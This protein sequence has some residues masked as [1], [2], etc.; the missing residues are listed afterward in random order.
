MDSVLL[1]FTRYVIRLRRAHPAFTRRSWLHG[2]P[3]D[4]GAEDVMWLTPA[5]ERM[6]DEDWSNG[7]LKSLMVYLNGCAVAD[8]GPDGERAHDD[9]FIL[10]F[11]ASDKSVEFSLAGWVSSAEW[12]VVI[13]TR[14]KATVASR[15]RFRMGDRLRVS[16]RSIV[17]LKS[18][19]ANV[20]STLSEQSIT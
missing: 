9:S 8:A 20:T 11:N 17:V 19:R 5:G 4:G 16:A 13:N 15:R 6:N 2:K 7:S 3:I 12:P 14:S 10:M 18:E 1:D